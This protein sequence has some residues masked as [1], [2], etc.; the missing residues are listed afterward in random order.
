MEHGLAWKALFATLCLAVVVSVHAQS[1]NATLSGVVRDPSGAVIPNATITAT[2]IATGREHRVASS[3]DGN[4][5]L[6]DLPIGDYKIA[7]SGT[8]FKT[9]AIPAV[10]L[11]TAQAAALD[12][13]LQI[14]ATTDEIVV[15][16]EIPL[17]NTQSSSVGQTVENKSIESQPLNGRAF[18]QLVALVPGASYT[19]GGQGTAT[20]GAS[21]R[22]NQVNVQINGSGYVT[23]GWL[24]DGGDITEYEQGGTNVQPDVDALSE[25]K[26]FSA[27]MPAEYG[28]TGNVIT[29]TMKSGGNQFHG[30]VFEFLRNDII[31]AANYFTGTD[32]LKRNQFGGTFSGPIKRDKVFFFSDF[33]ET[34]QTQGIPFSLTVPTDAQRAGIFPKAIKD[35]INGG[36]FANNT[37]P[38]NRFAR[39][40]TYFLPFLPTAAQSKFTG[41]QALD[42]IKGDIKVDAA[43]STKDHL[44][45]RYSIV[46]NSEQDP[47]QFPAL[48]YQ[49]LSSRAQNIALGETHI[50]NEHWLNELRIGYYRDYFLFSGILMGT[51]FETAAGVTGYEQTQIN[52]SFPYLTLSGYSSFNGSY[53]G[54]FPKSNRVQTRQYAD[55]V[56]YNKGKHEVRFGF[57]MWAQHHSFVHGQGQEGSFGFTG[58]YTGDA[59]ADFLLG[60]PFSAYRSFPLTLY[61]NIG[62]EYAAFGQDTWHAT[63]DLTLDFGI[64]YERNP[65][66]EGINGGTTGFDYNTGNLVI[67]MQG[68]QLIDPNI[69]AITPIAY[70]LFADRIEGTDT[71]HLPASIRKTGPGQLAPRFGLAYKP[72]G[73]DKFV[74]RS[75][76]GIFPLFFDT[77]VAQFAT[78]SPPFLVAQT[79]NN[80]AGTPAF[81]WANAFQGQPIISPNTTKAKC[82]N[83]QVA[84]AT[85]LAPLLQT[86][87]VALQHTY[88]EEY[89]LQVQYQL[90][91]GLSTTIG[92]VGN[93]TLHGQQYS[94]PTNTPSA[95]PLQAPNSGTP[96]T[97]AV[98][99]RRPF[100]QWGQINAGFTF[101]AAHYDALQATL[102]KRFGKGWYALVSY[103]HAKCLDNGST[104]GAPIALQY[105]PYNYGVCSFDIPNN[106]TVSS[107]YDLPFGK[108]KKFLNHGGFANYVIGNWQIAGIFMDRTGQPYT[109]VL[110]GDPANIGVSGTQFPIKVGNP[111]IA[112]TLANKSVHYFDPGAYAFPSVNGVQVATSGYIN[113]VNG[114]DTLRSQGLVDFDT[115]LKKNINISDA[116]SF[117]LRLESFNVAN[118]PTFAAP[119][120]TITLGATLNNSNS[121]GKVS[122]TLNNNRIFQAALKF[123]F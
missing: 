50:F 4:Y 12:F 11:H 7:V 2:E 86:E 102:E 10:T 73:S 5:A 119:N 84:Y 78:Q 72:G 57:Q 112:H 47:N 123:F 89:N 93:H 108:G 46:D 34:R 87:A 32:V 51:D 71:L 56:S 44:F 116:K 59:F 43:L 24:L 36:T 122:A 9:E 63:K 120:A 18:W 64:R 104:E 101:G 109:P 31:D 16:T 29:V 83:T 117:E 90:S 118:H 81:T 49:D 41:K 69:Q 27:N 85:C 79:V 52:P 53:S 92:Y 17:L 77:N 106:L 68:G 114:R 60:Y 3:A 103:S 48:K 8:G 26:V 82:A 62:R 61:G 75:A 28:H 88:M 35:P 39:Q 20:G 45:G 94:V 40:A 55:T 58:Q 121:A 99:A 98:Q 66:F 107:V 54:N 96:T 37:I 67:P 15:T 21:I 105:L 97:A 30:T 111:N 110:S 113:L 14:G 91:P 115:T 1:T 33:E 100:P 76:F 22:S 42:I 95:I 80:P 74:I 13:A 70:P 25:F 23:N 65:F 6:T 38:T 19:P